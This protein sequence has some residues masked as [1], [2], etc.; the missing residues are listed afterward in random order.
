MNCPQYPIIEPPLESHSVTVVTCACN[1][2]D[3]LKPLLSQVEKAFEDLGFRLPML[4]I[5]DGST[6]NSESIL[7]ELEIQYDFLTVICHS[8]RFG[9]TEC[10][11]TAIAHTNTDW[12]YLTPCDLES[13][14]KIDLPLLINGCK[15]GIDVVAGWRQNRQDGKILAS[16]IANFTCRL[17][18]GLNIHDMNWIKLIRRDLL[19]MLPLEKVTYAYVLPVLAALGYRIIEIPTPWYSRT[20]GRSKFGTKRLITSAQS[21][22]KLWWWFYF[23]Y[24]SQSK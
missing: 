24:S 4:L 13:D 15:P 5:D 8:R 20:A 22:W 14:P 10:L 18:F 1:E 23:Q 3:N 11:K 19:I 21:F 2:R 12:L 7:K 9:L 6:D 17:T 16:T